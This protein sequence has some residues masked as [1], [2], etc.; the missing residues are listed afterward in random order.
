MIVS[1]ADDHIA[2]QWLISMH[3]LYVDT[4]VP[5]KLHDLYWPDGVVDYDSY[6][7]SFTE[8]A[9]SFFEKMFDLVNGFDA[10]SHCSSNF[11]I[12][13]N[14]DVARSRSLVNAYH[15]TG[16]MYWHVGGIY[17]YKYARR[18][19]QWKFTHMKF[20]KTFQ[21]GDPHYHDK[22]RALGETAE[23]KAEFARF[24]RF[25]QLPW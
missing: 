14:G 13:I 5:E 3:G 2:I 23:R 15:T 9:K 18:N 6:G 16:D 22:A 24:D 21:H 8:N 4:R 7:E 1:L 17:R 20:V 19:G 10:T 11:D 25:E 12:E